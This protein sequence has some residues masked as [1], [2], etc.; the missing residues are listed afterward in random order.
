[1]AGARGDRPII[2]KRRAAAQ[3]QFAARIIAA[4]SALLIAAGIAG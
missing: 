2:G 4:R 3:F 1:M